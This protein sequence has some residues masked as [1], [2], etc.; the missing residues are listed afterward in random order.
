MPVFDIETGPLPEDILR[1]QLPPFD[2]DVACPHPGVFDS[3]TVKY[4]NAKK[5]DKR[6]EILDAA[7]TAHEN[8]VANYEANKH[9]MIEQ[10]R[11]QHWGK[12]IEGAA[13]DPIKGRVLAVGFKD[14]ENVGKEYLQGNV[15]TEEILIRNTWNQFAFDPAEKLIGHNIFGFDLPFLVKRSWLL[16]IDVPEWIRNGRYWSTRFV[17]SMAEWNFGA[18]GGASFVKLEVLAAAFGIPGK[19]DGITGADFDRLFH[20]TPEERTQALEYLE[21]DLTMTWEIANRMQLV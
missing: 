16:G 8:L 2:P 12:Y 21:N 6:A 15:I 17:D 7:W 4:G 13:L 18:M 9:A 3:S 5:E 10:A 20:G 1:K 19:P 11:E 14:G